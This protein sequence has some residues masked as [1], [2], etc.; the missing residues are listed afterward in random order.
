MSPRQSHNPA[1]TLTFAILLAVPASA[2]QTVPTVQPSATGTT[3]TSRKLRA[4]ITA[5]RGLAEVRLH[6]DENWQPAKVG[7]IIDE[8]AEI[9]TGPRSAVRCTIPP[10]QTF[11][12]D[13][14]GVIKLLTVVR[15]SNGK[16]K[17]DLGMKY[18]RTDYDIAAGG[19]EHESTIRSPNS[20]LAVRGTV[21]SLQDERP[22]PPLARSYTGRAQFNA[23]KKQTVAFGGKA[24]AKV[25]G[26]K[27]NAAESVYDE[28]FVDPTLAF[29][30]DQ[31]EQQLVANLIS[32][33][34]VVSLDRETGLRVVRGGK[35]PTDQQLLPLLPGNL[36]FV[37]RWGGNANLDLS[38]GTQVGNEV[39]YPSQELAFSK[40]G[41]KTA[42]DHQGGPNGGIEIISW[43]AGFPRDFY[44]IAINHVSGPTVTAN[45]QTYL[46]GK[47]QP[48]LSRDAN[49][50]VSP[51][52]TV[53]LPVVHRPPGKNV[54]QTLGGL[55][56]LTGGD[57]PL[58][59]PMRQLLKELGPTAAVEK[60][61]RR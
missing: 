13:R 24:K 4:T 61:G 6:E 5:V 28:S 50:N 8:D 58:T 18:G 52:P 39:V 49:G 30:R 57:T 23:F 32:S 55:V 21:V 19:V 34:A 31:A 11:T 2:L 9:R 12:I 48:I 46:N 33:G 40:S 51:V 15:M 53:T 45:V 22:F 44:I 54:Q 10:D 36:N 7:M 60:G 25:E 56:N 35:V 41:G 20:T 43:P 1:L 29:A 59:P 47:L 26:D 37:L 3:P 17:T 16:I 14:L 27:N 38:V 42:F